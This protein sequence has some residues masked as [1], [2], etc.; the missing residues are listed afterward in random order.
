MELPLLKLLNLVRSLE[1]EQSSTGK[2]KVMNLTSFFPTSNLVL[3]LSG[4]VLHLDLEDMKRS[5]K[6]SYIFAKEIMLLE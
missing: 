4:E 1:E 6:F 3:F 2:Y 5:M